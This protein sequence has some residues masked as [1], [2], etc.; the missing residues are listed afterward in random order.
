M[1]E[2]ESKYVLALDQGTTGTRAIIFNES[3]EIAGAAYKEFRQIYP[4][5]GWVEHDPTEILH[6]VYYTAAEALKA[7]NVSP[8]QIEAMGIANQDGRAAI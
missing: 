7:G 8:E 3:G 2:N 5:P 1:K 6:T 4:Q